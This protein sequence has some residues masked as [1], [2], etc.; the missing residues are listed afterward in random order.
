[1]YPAM[2]N[3]LDNALE[4][5]H[6]RNM[7][8]RRSSSNRYI[9][10]QKRLRQT[11]ARY[12]RLVNEYRSEVLFPNDPLW[13]PTV[14]SYVL[15]DSTVLNSLWTAE[16]KNR[17]FTALARCGKGKLSDVARRVGSKSL[18][19]VTAYIGLLEQATAW[20]KMS[21]R[22]KE[23]DFAMVPVAVEVTEQWLAFEEKRGQ[24]AGQNERKLSDDAESGREVQSELNAHDDQVLNVDG[25][26]ELAQWYVS[27]IIG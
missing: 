10:Q 13:S 17:F 14:K 12:T 21:K 20:R 2:D 18:A 27:S 11:T 3:T 19:E 7:H 4:N 16:E 8:A 25:A 6:R 24:V 23:F 9:P 15:S 5:A 1:M 22:H 26:N